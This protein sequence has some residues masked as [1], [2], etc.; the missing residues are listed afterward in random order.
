MCI[1]NFTKEKRNASVTNLLKNSTFLSYHF[2]HI[3]NLARIKFG[4]IGAKWQKSPKLN[5]C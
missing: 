2:Y 5:L 4:A 3:I 1:F